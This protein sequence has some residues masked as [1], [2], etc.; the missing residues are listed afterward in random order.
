MQEYLLLYEKDNLTYMLDKDFNLHIKDMSLFKYLEIL[1][2][3][4]GSSL[5]G[6]IDSFNY[7]TKNKY[8]PCLVASNKDMIYYL[9]TRSLNSHDNILINYKYLD[10]Y[11]HL[12]LDNTI[13]NFKNHKQYQINCNYRIL[14]RQKELM[15]KYLYQHYM[16]SGIIK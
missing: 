16:I 7:L 11:H 14:K 2:L 3:K 9:S 5:K 12:D 1:C 10:S 8:K 13:L 15:D 4:H 6:R